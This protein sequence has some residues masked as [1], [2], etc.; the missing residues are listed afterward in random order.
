MTKHLHVNFDSESVEAI[1]VQT[2][3]FDAKYNNKGFP[4]RRPRPRTGILLWAHS[5]AQSAGLFRLGLFRK[6]KESDDKATVFL[7]VAFVEFD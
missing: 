5:W 4:I 3:A 1:G 6:R 2:V 7:T